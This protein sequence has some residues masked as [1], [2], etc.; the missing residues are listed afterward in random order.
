MKYVFVLSAVMLA[1]CVQNGEK[2]FSMNEVSAEQRAHIKSICGGHQGCIEE[3]Y[4]MTL[5]IERRDRL[6]N[7]LALAD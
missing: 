7:Q 6:R 4:Y 3:E 5:E 2:K 1:A